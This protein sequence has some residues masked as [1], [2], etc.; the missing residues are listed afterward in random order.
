MGQIITTF[1]DLLDPVTPETFL[2]DIYGR[3]PL[4][5]PA[6]DAG[7]F[8][9]ILSWEGF[10]ELLDM[11]GIWTSASLKMKLDRRDV[12]PQLYCARTV[13]RNQ[14]NA[15]QPI[16]AKVSEFAR[17]GASLVCNEIETLTPGLRAVT[18]VLERTF[19]GRANCNLYCS[20]KDRQAFDS[21]YDK[22][23]VFALFLVGEKRWR[24]YEGRIEN[25]IHHALFANQTQEYLDSNKGRVVEEI[26]TR[27]GDLLYIPRGQFHDALATGE[28][29][30]HVTFALAV[31]NGLTL[32]TDAWERAAAD[33]LFRADLP[34]PAEPGFETRLADHLAALK[35][36]FADLIGGPAFV[37][38]A[39]QVQQAYAPRRHSCDL[40]TPGGGGSGG[41]GA[42][43]GYRV[44]DDAPKLVR[45]GPDWVLKGNDGAVPV[46]AGE[47]ER[48]AWIAGRARFS[49][50]DLASA[51]PRLDDAGRRRF[52]DEMTGRGLIEAD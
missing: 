33:P 26:T 17:R 20:W 51:F 29:S 49:E 31:P 15:W 27:P 52:L 13:D 24:L 40:P 34:S 35:D 38:R 25:P 30:L 23:E 4:H 16:P 11:S 18:G 28:A 46:T 42:A 47:G 44:R 8:S 7:K 5:V 41:G 36:A 6:A 10:T 22:H 9:A 14:Q 2:A 37:Q 39:K 48:I 1:A 12:P 43:A 3:K 45:R 32:L 50:S 19:N 21:H